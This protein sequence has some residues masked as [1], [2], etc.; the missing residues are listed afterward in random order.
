MI[1]N[2]WEEGLRLYE[3]AIGFSVKDLCIFS[4]WYARV[5]WKQ[6]LADAQG[7]MYIK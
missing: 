5:F 2:I 3:N 7:Q 1:S 6:S 4:F